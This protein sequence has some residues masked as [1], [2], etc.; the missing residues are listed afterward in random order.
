V[1]LSVLHPDALLFSL[2]TALKPTHFSE[3]ELYRRMSTSTRWT[4]ASRARQ[5]QLIRCWAPWTRSTGPRTVG[6]KARSSR[7][8]EAFRNDPE[9]RRAY[10]LIQK[11]LRDGRVTPELSAILDKHVPDI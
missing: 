6:G 3:N 9:A 8:A 4:A 2:A 7:N 1:L 10:L 11:F 5:S